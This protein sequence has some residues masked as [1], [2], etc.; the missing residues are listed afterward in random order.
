MRRHGLGSGVHEP[1]R[2]R[3][4]TNWALRRWAKWT[5]L[6][7]GALLLLALG[8]AWAVDHFGYTLAKEWAESAAGQRAVS[9]GMS[10]TLKV[11][12]RFAP[13]Q[14]AGWTIRTDSFTSRGWPGEAIGGLDASDIQAEFDPSAIWRG[15]WRISGV[16]IEHATISLLPPNDALKRP[17]LPKKPRPWYLF[18]LPSRIECG[19]IVCPDARLLYSFQG[20]SAR[21]ENANVQADLIG[22]DLQY[23]A[24]S[25][26]LE[27]PY[28]PPLRIELLKMLVTR[29]VIRVYTAQLTGLDQADPARV[30]LSGSLGM[31][32]N[33]SIEASGEIA[34]IPIEQILPDEL[35][36]VVHGRATGKLSWRRDSTGHHLDSDGEVSLDGA[37]IDDL[38]PF[39]QLALLHGNTDLNGFAFDTATCEFHLHE[40]R[41]KLK[42]RAASANKL[43]LDGS[44]DYD[45]ATKH[46]QIDLAIT[47]L[48]LRTWLPNEFKPGAAGMARAHLQW[49]GQL[50][51]VRDSFGHVTLS[52]DGGTMR[53]PEILRR[54]LQAKKLRAPE[55]IQF[56]TAAMDLHYEDNTFQ[57]TRGN[58]DLPGILSAQMSG[59]L[60]PGNLLQAQMAWQGL[61]IEDWLPKDLADEF[62]GAIQ[63]NARMEVHKWKMGDG[64]YGGQIRLVSGELRYTPFQS[65]LARFLN[66]RALLRLPLTQAEVSWTWTNKRLVV[67]DL[68]LR[69]GDRLAVT[70]GF[71]VAPDRTLS[72]TLQVGTRAEYVRRMAGLGDAVFRLQRD[73][74]RWAE[75]RLSG[76]T[77]KPKQDLSSQLI[78]QLPHHPSAIFSLG[79]KVLSWCV[80]NW[81]GADK[82]WQKPAAARSS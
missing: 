67:T 45:L 31:R 43:T 74:L 37:R 18:F 12:G 20:H 56:K 54:M 34:E 10:K 46:A 24:T 27:M 11:D 47:D 49:Q 2:S 48:P 33:K 76:T 16:Q 66:D 1:V 59:T 61:T 75:V 63:G 52:L 15:A 7:A 51:T 8:L 38:S 14:I 65:M 36:S 50:R 13:L 4:V 28:L 57:L 82:E 17:A 3:S 44:V 35:R 78:S 26:V 6:A 73:G 9:S 68:V 69:S 64:N 71:T 62:S 5:A 19:P 53:T 25:G 81:F 79:F 40:D 42:L 60:L 55:T 80:G 22:K 32:E 58:F 21:I 70:G 72:G 39:R 23:T 77:R 41:A 29:P 30:T